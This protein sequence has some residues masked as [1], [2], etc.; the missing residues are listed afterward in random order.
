MGDITAIKQFLTAFLEPVPEELWS[1]L[2]TRKDK[3]SHWFQ[4][5]EGVNSIAKQA[6]ALSK[7]DDVYISTSF[8]AKKGGV[9]R[10]IK[11]DESA[12]LAALWAD[13][14]IAEP[15]V[16]KKY[17]LPGSEEQATEIVSA[18]GLPASALIH[19]GHGLQAWWFFT[20]FLAFDSAE[21]RSEGAALARSWH[22]TVVVRASERSCTIDSVFDLARVMRLP[23][24]VNRKAEPVD[25][26]V[27]ELPAT[28][29]NG[30]D[31]SDHTVDEAY[32]KDLGISA[33]RSYQVNAG[34]ITLSPKAE[35]SI[36]KFEILVENDEKF[37][38]T[39]DRKRRDFADQS[40]SSYDLSLAV[41][42][43]SVGWTDQ[44][45]VN[46]IIASRRKHGDDLKLRVDYYG[47]TIAKARDALGREQATVQ[48]EQ[49]TDELL[50]AKGGGDPDE[51]KRVRREAA[52][53][54][55]QQ[56][57]FEVS[58]FIRQ[59][60]S[61]PVYYALTPLGRVYLGTAADLL[62][63]TKTRANIFSHTGILIPRFKPAAWDQICTTIAEIAEDE[64]VGIESTERGQ[65]Y[66]WISEYLMAH[67]PLDLDQRDEA[68]QS[69][70]P[71]IDEHGQVVVF[72]TA[73]SRW[74]WVHANSRIPSREIARMLRDFH[75][76]PGKLNVQAGDRRTTKSIW[77]MD[78]PKE[79]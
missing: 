12:G 63:W 25:V 34:E 56:L 55:A 66:L 42:A 16:H 20:E 71:F 77:R 59:L 36:E 3:K 4:V 10:R 79:F 22:E 40:P 31:F 64:D 26:L 5:S 9:Y 11:A 21:S 48:M 62:S 28:R 43:A 24:T 61:P 74:L 76:M 73:F 54:V 44:E 19:S 41:T 18:T 1:L 17:N 13:V 46:L 33:E 29:Y 69:E 7:D 23:G 70:E 75:A 32:L 51:V 38:R 39:W 27:R 58:G 53:A 60:A 57:A 8:A 6:L 50:Q 49:L 2:W 72:S 37:Q 67:P 15:D 65:T 30:G 78:P 45:I 68:G 52:D 35:V 14:D 47:R